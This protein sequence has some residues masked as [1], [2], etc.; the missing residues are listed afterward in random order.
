M[1]DRTKADYENLSQQLRAELKQWENDWV[2]ANG[3][4]KPARGDI[5]QNRD[6]AQKYKDYNKFR[7][8]LAGNI[9]PP[10]REDASEQRKRKQADAVLPS[11]QTPSK[12]PKHAATP[13]KSQLHADDV[14]TAVTPSLSRKLFSPALPTSIGP[15]PQKDGRVL[16]L[17]DLLGKTPSKSTGEEVVSLPP[18]IAT[19]SRRNSSQKADD[20]VLT[21]PNTDRFARTP[22]SSRNHRNRILLNSFMGITSPLQKRDENS[23]PSN[24]NN[25]NNNNKS[26][27]SRGSVSKLQFATPAFLRRST[28]P[29]PPVDENGEWKV[30]PIKLPRKPLGRGLSSVVASLRRLEEE[31]LDEEL[32]V[33]RE[34]EMEGEAATFAT[35]SQK[36]NDDEPPLLTGEPA[37]AQAAGIEGG[38]GET[39]SQQQASAA[40]LAEEKPVLL[41]GFDD[42]GIYDSDE[43]EQLDRGQPLRV[44][45][46]KGQKR[47]TRRV[48]MRPTRK[49]RPTKAIDEGNNHI[50]GDDEDEVVPETQFDAARPTVSDDGDDHLLLSGSD[51]DDEAAQDESD[52]DDRKKTKITKVQPKTSKKPQGQD[53]SADDGKKKKEEGI[54]AKT[55]RKVKATAHANFKRLKLKNNGAK[56]GP[57]YNSRF[58][59]RR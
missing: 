45:K 19:P 13:I 55:A 26:P 12:R 14:S 46:K 58:R 21:T 29:L 10:A 22:S 43:G 38:E 23:Q 54:V 40:A 37:T 17:F 33:M 2:K 5:K 52:L 48:N 1:D 24:N 11:T 27:S 4:K 8:I 35:S 56:G 49:K 50:S 15:T 32:D 7:D 6:I 39:T 28:A 20:T 3:G 51:F 41:G 44:F 9:P 31:V 59:R 53:K 42:E 36:K 18:I 25:N 57:G 34:M 16:G 30:E 47:T